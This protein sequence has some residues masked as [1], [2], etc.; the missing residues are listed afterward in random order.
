MGYDREYDDRGRDDRGRGDR[1]RGDDRRGGGDDRRGGGGY[2][3][4]DQSGH[5]GGDDRRG[6]GGYRGGGGGRGGG[7][8]RGRG[9]GGRG[10]GRG[11]GGGRGGAGGLKNEREERMKELDNMR[12][13][14]ASSIEQIKGEMQHAYDPVSV[15]YC[16]AEDGDD[17]R[18]I[19][20]IARETND[21]PIVKVRGELTVGRPIH[22]KTNQFKIDINEEAKFYVYQ[23]EFKKTSTGKMD[24]ALKKEDHRKI[25]EQLG[26]YIGIK[27]AFDGEKIAITYKSLEGIK[28]DNCYDDRD[29]IVAKVEMETGK[30]P[31]PVEIML[32]KITEMKMEKLAAYLNDDSDDRPSD[33]LQIIDIIFRTCPMLYSSIVTKSKSM[34][35]AIANKKGAI[36]I[37]DGREVWHG[38]NQSARISH[39]KNLGT[40]ALTLN[41]DVSYSIVMQ[42]GK[43]D[44]ILNE[45]QNRRSLEESLKHLSFECD[46]QYYK[47]EGIDRFDVASCNVLDD[48]RQTNMADFYHRKKGIRLPG[49]SL[50]VKST[51]KTMNGGRK[52]PKCF[53]A[54]LCTLLP[55]QKPKVESERHKA[56]MIRASA[57]TAPT[58]METI[59]GFVANEELYPKELEKF[60]LKLNKEPLEAEGRVLPAPE[61]VGGDEK[62]IKVHDGAWKSGTFYKGSC[63]KLWMT[64]MIE[65]FDGRI[66]EHDF[67][68]FVTAFGKHGN[69]KVGCDVKPPVMKEKVRTVQE[70]LAL[71]ESLKTKGKDPSKL[72][73]IL[74]CGKD[75]GTEEYQGIKVLAELNYG[76]M[77]QFVRAKNVQKRAPD[78]IHNIWLKV[79]EK[80]GGTNWKVAVPLPHTQIPYMVIGCS[81]S[82]G[83]AKSIEPTFIGFAGSTKQGASGYVNYVGHQDPRLSVVTEGVLENAILHF[84]SEFMAK[85]DNAKPERIIWYRGGA[86]E[87]SLQAILK[88]EMQVL[89]AIFKRKDPNYQPGI[90]FIVSI[91][92]HRQ[93]L[94]AADAQD[95]AGQGKNVPAGTAM[96]GYGGGTPGTFHFH[97]ASHAGC[98]TLNPT[99]YQVVHDDNELTLDSVVSMTYALSLDSKRCEKSISE[100]APVRLASLRAERARNHYQGSKALI[101]NR[102]IENS[103]MK[104]HLG[105]DINK[106][107]TRTAFKK[108]I[109]FI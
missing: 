5:R 28:K 6:G 12:L 77:T 65:D 38:I 102:E 32:T 13:P 40:N 106:I 82:H 51:A 23:A 35:P 73:L 56:E 70:F 26:T 68:D 96:S 55:G 97:L 74:I 89:R 36:P 2:D 64:V 60:G 4:R 21:M 24:K 72:D 37:S 99:F 90:T 66:S 46:G 95:Y 79:N 53:P 98:G 57:E 78:V 54:V 83:E 62:Q 59:K 105:D 81:F 33:V 1:D 63:L 67:S 48:G 86:S 100:V 103:G 44:A 18:R 39:W 104:S 42:G 76:V 3:R 107:T 52:S 101:Q 17:R 94:F 75:R 15:K 50:V 87:G 88:N 20:D 34:F 11:G 29:R 58:R 19:R 31:V 69:E 7:G 43:I 108:N 25:M 61:M 10:R 30:K 47:F 91:R 41:V 92:N 45:T 71:M 80:L 27:F 109:F 16:R 49:N 8:F 85:N 14:G 93:K 9:G 22:L 84:V